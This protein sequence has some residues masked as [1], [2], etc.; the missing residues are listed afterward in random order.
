MC[1]DNNLR[2]GEPIPH[3]QTVPASMERVWQVISE[4]GNLVY[5]HPFC[6]SNPVEIWPGVGSRDK[7]CYY[8]GL[9]LVRDFTNWIEGSG[10]D[11]IASAEL[12]LQFKVS[13]RIIQENS[14]N[15]SLNLVIQQVLEQDSERKVQQFTRLL[16]K[17][18]QQV[19]QGFE[20]YMRSGERVTRNQFGPHRLFSPAVA[21]Q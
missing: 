7:V 9:V 5:F 6:E 10:Y 13:W 15:S 8:N 11:L 16:A 17:Y 20:Y 4:P 2:L 18:L 21:E 14:E 1:A 19:L 3:S 12:G